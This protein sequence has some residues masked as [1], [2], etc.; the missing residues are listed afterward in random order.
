MSYE[1]VVFSPSFRWKNL[2]KQPS[3]LVDARDRKKSGPLREDEVD[4]DKIAQ[5][6]I[7]TPSL[8]FQEALTN[9]LWKN[10]NRRGRFHGPLNG[11]VLDPKNPDRAI[12]PGGTLELGRPGQKEEW[13]T[14]RRRSRSR[15]NS[16]VPHKDTISTIS[17]GAYKP[18]LEECQQ[19]REVQTVLTGANTTPLGGRTSGPVITFTDRDIRRGRTGC[20]EPMVISIV[21]KEY[22][23]ERVLVD[24]GSSANILYWTTTKRLGIQNLTKCEG[25]L[26]GFVGE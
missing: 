9:P 26:Y 21:A 23:I 5:F 6:H 17:G 4:Q 12:N 19:K 10:A 22:K 1:V 3:R 16:P 20:D 14:K 2:G 11:G 24:Q 25:A 15:Q 13:P 7:R 18:P 8:P